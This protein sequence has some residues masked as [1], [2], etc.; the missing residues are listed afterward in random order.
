MLGVGGRSGTREVPA[1]TG[2]RACPCPGR[3]TREV[4]EGTGGPPVPEGVFLP[5]ILIRTSSFLL[6]PHHRLRPYPP[7]NESAITSA[8]AA[9]AAIVPAAPIAVAVAAIIIAAEVARV[10]RAVVALAAPTAAVVIPAAVVVVIAIAAAP[11]VTAASTGNGR[12]ASVQP[13]PHAGPVRVGCVAE[14]V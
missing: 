6:V 1:G 11:T 8:A 5:G 3:G 12:F 10:V 14:V 13:V 2:V 4:P 9:I 7:L